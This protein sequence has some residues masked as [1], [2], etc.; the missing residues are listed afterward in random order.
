MNIQTPHQNNSFD[1]MD[2]FQHFIESHK[3]KKLALKFIQNREEK[4]PRK[5]TKKLIKKINPSKYKMPQGI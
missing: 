3:Q 2:I 1:L 5:Y 4:N